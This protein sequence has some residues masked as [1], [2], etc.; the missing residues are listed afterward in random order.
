MWRWRCSRRD[1]RSRR[2]LVRAA[3]GL[4]TL[5][6]GSQRLRL[7]CHR[8]SVC[9]EEPLQLPRQQL[10]PA[11][12]AVQAGVQP[13]TL[14]RHKQERWGKWWC[15]NNAHQ[16]PSDGVMWAVPLLHLRLCAPQPTV[17]T[18]ASANARLGR[19]LPAGGWRRW[20]PSSKTL[21]RRPW[22]P[23]L[24]HS[25]NTWVQFVPAANCYYRTKYMTVLE[26]GRKTPGHW[27][28]FN[29]KSFISQLYLYIYIHHPVPC[30]LG[31]KSASMKA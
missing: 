17:R 11:G 8:V 29:I 1:P 7:Q 15:S 6:S 3:G 9:A 31:Y 21:T 23:T 12:G 19:T 22:D 13:R 27:V 25:G 4:Q 18:A 10:L 2:L 20:F 28:F 30:S 24:T 14:P 16:A 5:L 26:L